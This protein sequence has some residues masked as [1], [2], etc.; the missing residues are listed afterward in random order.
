MKNNYLI[1]AI[2]LGSTSTKA[3]VFENTRLLAVKTIR[4]TAAEFSECKTVFEQK[5][6]RV[7]A[8]Q[9]FLEETG[10]SIGTVDAI[11]ARGGITK[12][13]S[14]GVYEISEQMLE[15]LKAFGS[16]HA[17][18]VGCFA[19][20][21]LGDAYGIPSYTVDPPSVDEL[22]AV[23]RLTGF[24]EIKRE[25]NFH[26]LNQKRIARKCAEDLN[27][28]YENCRFIV[29]HMGGGITVGAHL[30]GRVVDTN[31]G[32]NGEGPYTPER[33]GGIALAP[34][35][36]MCYSGKY[37]KEE[38]FAHLYGKGGMKAHLGTTDM[39][40]IEDMAMAGDEK[41]EMLLESLAYQ[42]SKEICA[43]FAI[44]DGK[45]DAIILTGGLAY[46]VS[47][48]GRIKKRVD[49]LAPVRT[50]PGEDE[51]A[52]LVE[53]VLPVLE[54]KSRVSIYSGC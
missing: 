33:P 35:I 18:S 43:R 29:A 38:M 46:S 12:P 53:G 26:A 6:I 40:R 39:V 30:Y 15:D 22:A 27:K 5:D 1:L 19:A 41:A 9:R 49:S 31:H 21:E 47:F 37:T 48:T 52:A 44:L 24:P 50:Y 8:I 34:I 36:E 7:H 42:I 54:G 17:S 28:E 14:S 16:M 32:L 3:A 13:V 23:V 51:L 45:A 25:S 4:H 10:I 11:V 2:N 20:R